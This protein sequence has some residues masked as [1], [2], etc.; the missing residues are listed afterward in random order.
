M[1]RLLHAYPLGLMNWLHDRNVLVR[2]KR[3]AQLWLLV[4]HPHRCS[5][6]IANLGKRSLLSE[7]IHVLRAWT[8]LEGDVARGVLERD[9]VVST[10]LGAKHLYRAELTR[11]A[12][13][14]AAVEHILHAV[15]VHLILEHDAQLVEHTSHTDYVVVLLDDTTRHQLAIQREISVYAGLLL[16]L[17]EALIR[18]AIDRDVN[19]TITELTESAAWHVVF[20]RVRV[21]RLDCRPDNILSLI[22]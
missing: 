15:K 16:K 20:L 12:A 17:L 18:L 2:L 3:S 10:H 21:P 6:E 5:H 4:P 13:I 22:P 8:E 1:R 11:R 9:A 7:N 14:L 19:R